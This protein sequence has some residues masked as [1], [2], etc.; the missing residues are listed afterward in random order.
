MLGRKEDKRRLCGHQRSSGK[1]N[2]NV[3]YETVKELTQ[4]LV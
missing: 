3:F 2:Q 4:I 1:Y